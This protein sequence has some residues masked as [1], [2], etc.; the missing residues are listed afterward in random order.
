MSKRRNAGEWVWLRANAGFTG[1]SNRLKAEIQPE[2]PGTAQQ[3]HGDPY[4]CMLDCGDPDCREWLTLFTEPDPQNN[5]ERFPLCHVSECEMF[6]EP[7]KGGSH[8]R[9]GQV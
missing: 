7:Q 9:T 3:G 1:E 2:G 5:A 6:D 4:P 8:D